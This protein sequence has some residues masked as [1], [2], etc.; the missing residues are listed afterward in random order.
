MMSH[1]ASETADVLLAAA[2]LDRRELDTLIHLFNGQANADTN[3]DDEREAFHAITRLL[4]RIRDV[5]TENERN[6]N[7]VERIA[8]AHAGPGPDIDDFDGI[9]AGLDCVD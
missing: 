9:V 5:N 4:A 2:A 1:C 6:L 7:R 3:S 8:L